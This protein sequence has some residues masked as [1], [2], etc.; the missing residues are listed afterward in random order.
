MLEIILML[1]GLAF[2]NSESNNTENSAQSQITIEN[3]Q[4]TDEETNSEEIP[5]D[6]TG[7]Q[8]QPIPPK[9]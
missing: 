9:K 7:G 5:V 4:S 2:P 6:D 3:V 8:S 1:L